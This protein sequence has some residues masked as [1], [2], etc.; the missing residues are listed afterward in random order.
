MTWCHVDAM[1]ILDDDND[2]DDNDELASNNGFELCCS[3]AKFG[4]SISGGDEGRPAA[5]G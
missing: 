3:T 2:I 5:A 4:S 1:A